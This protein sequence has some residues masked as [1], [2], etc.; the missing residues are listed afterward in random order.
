[1]RTRLSFD[2]LS[3]TERSLTSLF[4][5]TGEL[6]RERERESNGRTRSVIRHGPRTSS[7]PSS[8][9]P[10]RLSSPCNSR[11]PLFRV[12]LRPRDNGEMSIRTMRSALDDFEGD[13]HA[14]Q[15]RAAHIDQRSGGGGGRDAG[16]RSIESYVNPRTC[17]LKVKDDQIDC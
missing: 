6:Q 16:S 7:L 17:S 8:P 4:A 14:R 1:M 3:M 2:P 9:L 12:C 15:R 5:K 10:V 11:T 13:H